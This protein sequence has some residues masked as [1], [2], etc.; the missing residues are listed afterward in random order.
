M[1]TAVFLCPRAWKTAELGGAHLFADS[2][3]LNPDERMTEAQQKLL[4]YQVSRALSSPVGDAKLWQESP[5]G[6]ATA[7]NERLQPCRKSFLELRP[8]RAWQVQAS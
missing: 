3:A 8:R 2:A 5:L 1:T 4:P 6:R 7:Q